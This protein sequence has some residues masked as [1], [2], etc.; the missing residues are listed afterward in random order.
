MEKHIR[1]TGRLSKQ[2][3]NVFVQVIGQSDCRTPFAPTPHAIEG[4]EASS[5]DVQRHISIDYVHFKG[6]N[7]FPFTETGKAWSE[8]G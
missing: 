8:T 5:A 7:F 1:V 2:V 3:E 6:I 4:T